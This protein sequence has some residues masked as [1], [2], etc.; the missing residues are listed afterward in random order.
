[1]DRLKL[2]SVAADA[3]LYVKEDLIIPQDLTF[4]DLIAKAQRQVGTALSF[5]VHDD[6]RVEVL[7]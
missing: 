3:L 4:Y 6:V 2:N 1:V 5:D 7:N